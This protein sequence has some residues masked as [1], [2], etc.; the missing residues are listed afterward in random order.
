VSP[1]QIPPGSPCR[2]IDVNGDEVGNCLFT[3]LEIFENRWHY[4]VLWKDKLQQLDVSNFTLIPL[5]F[6]E[7]V[8]S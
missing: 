1:L 6:S 4:V 8:S 7:E 3:E 2:I 5:L